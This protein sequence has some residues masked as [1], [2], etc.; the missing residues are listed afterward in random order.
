MPIG[1]S[2]AVSEAVHG[3]DAFRVSEQFIASAATAGGDSE[4]PGS[5]DCHENHQGRLL[6]DWDGEF[7]GSAQMSLCSL[8]WTLSGTTPVDR[9]IIIII[10]FVSRRQGSE[11]LPDGM[12]PMCPASVAAAVPA[13]AATRVRPNLCGSIRTTSNRCRVSIMRER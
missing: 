12:S 6:P 1:R 13:G 3:D 9:A 10:I 4:T 8:T 5:T 7:E 11:Q 2:T